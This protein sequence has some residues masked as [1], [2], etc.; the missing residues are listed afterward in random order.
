MM[1]TRT[2]ANIDPDRPEKMR[3]AIHVALTAV[4]VYIT[5]E[6]VARVP[7][8]T[9]RLRGSLTWKTAEG[10]SSVRAPARPGDGVERPARENVVY[11]GTNVVYAAQKE[12]GGTIFPVN[13]QALTVPISPAAKGKRARDFP[14]A[15]LVKLKSGGAI[16]ARKKG[17]YG[18]EAL[19]ALRKSVYQRPQ[20]F[21]RPAFDEN[22]QEIRDIFRDHLTRMVVNG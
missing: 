21:L 9:G 1:A 13:A 22:R 18:I 7:V 6:A 10:G 5:G 16:I 20:P 2:E 8:D 12:Y 3:K 17:K 19:F 14:E 11:I 15:F 4:G